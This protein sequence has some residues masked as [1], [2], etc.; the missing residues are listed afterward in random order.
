MTTKREH[1]SQHP[2]FSSLLSFLL[3]VFGPLF[4]LVCP[5]IH[6]AMQLC[7][8]CR[9]NCRVA[10]LP[11]PLL[12]VSIHLRV[13]C[14]ADPVSAVLETPLQDISQGLDLCWVVFMHVLICV[15]YF[16]V[17]T[18]HSLAFLFSF[19]HS[20]SDFADVLNVTGTVNTITPEGFYNTGNGHVQIKISHSSRV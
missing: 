11:V 20:H 17:S 9:Q 19:L 5:I 2:T 12:V 15:C 1:Q 16:P 8:L 4:P 13:S 14:G 10:L 18:P 3:L 7:L 6:A